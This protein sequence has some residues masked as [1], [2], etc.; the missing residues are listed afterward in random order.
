M[1]G[2][3]HF[4]DDSFDW[5]TSFDANNRADEDYNYRALDGSYVLDD[6]YIRK[7]KKHRKKKSH[8]PVVVAVI[9]VILLA[10]AGVA[11]FFG[12]RMLGEAREV[13]DQAKE[14]VTLVESMPDAILAGDTT[15]LDAT[16][17]RIVTLADQINSTVHGKLWNLATYIPVYGTDIQSA[18]TMGDTLVDLA[19][20]A[21]VPLAESL[22]GVSLSGLFSN[23]RINVEKLTAMTNAVSQVSPVIQDAAATMEAL[24]EAHVRQVGEYI[25]KV[26]EPL[27]EIS[28]ILAETQELL[29]LLPDVFG[30]S[31]TR[32]YFVIAQ[33]QAELR[34]I[35]GLP[36]AVGF[37]TVD[38]GYIE[39]GDF[40]SVKNQ[41]E[42]SLDGY[43]GETEEEYLAFKGEDLYKNM[44][45]LT[46]LPEFERVGQLAMDYC[47][48]YWPDT[49]VDG[50]FAVTPTLLQHLMAL[51]GSSAEVQGQTLDGSTTAYMLN[52]GAYQ[53]YEESEVATKSDEFFSEAADVCVDAVFEN[54]GNLSLT[55]LMDLL[56]YDAARQ[57]FLM[58]MADEKEQA[59]VRNLKFA[60]NLD[61]DTASPQLGVY[62]NDYTWSAIDWYLGCET[63][64][65]QAVNNNDGTYTYQVTTYV[66]SFLTRDEVETQ[67]RYV[68]GYNGK[69]TSKADIMTRIYFFAP[70]GGSISNLE[71]SYEGEYAD[72]MLALCSYNG[73]RTVWGHKAYVVDLHTEAEGMNVIKY[74]VTTGVGTENPITVRQT[75]MAN[76]NNGNVVLSWEQEAQSASL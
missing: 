16:T 48:A 28:A 4:N 70:Y 30:A 59:A 64:V 33:K 47:A 67:P 44:A 37:V 65:G 51:T 69:K 53:L 39:V 14:V 50:V 8:V 34:S 17:S 49:K 5:D 74:T 38:N 36:G 20:N 32:T 22:H 18:Q 25:N 26:R 31:G 40:A 1:A 12:Y 52:H 3:T 21:L 13:K 56:D 57:N 75:P 29:P 46:F 35:A 24:P 55:G 11:G 19:N 43:V 9:F 15:S 54:M 63:R 7:R 41:K 68:W 2:G 10:L 42:G 61:Y 6:G 58:W 45:E 27:S 23:K 60:G 71:I 66:K 72:E 76:E 73:E 62:L